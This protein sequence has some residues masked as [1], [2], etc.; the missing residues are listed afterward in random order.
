MALARKALKD[1]P[2]L[3]E[4]HRKIHAMLRFQGVKV[5]RDR[6]LRI[7]EE[8]DLLS[9]PQGK[10]DLGPRAHDGVIQTQAPNVMWGTDL[11]F[12]LTEKETYNQN[13]RRQRHGHLS[14]RQVHQNF[15]AAKDAA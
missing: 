11:T 6:L 4:G 15:L 13:W 7:L 10:R 14:P 3:G 9:S 1:S 2:F 5:G 12:T 8:N